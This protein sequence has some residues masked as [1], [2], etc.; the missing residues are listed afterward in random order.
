MLLHAIVWPFYV[1]N[2][3][4]AQIVLTITFQQDFFAVFHAAAHGEAPVP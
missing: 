2:L 1:T 4:H 3:I